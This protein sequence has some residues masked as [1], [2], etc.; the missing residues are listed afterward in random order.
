MAAKALF[1][2]D[3]AGLMLADVNGRL[4]WASASDERA[5]A[6]EDIEG[7]ADGPGP[8]PGRLHPGGPGGDADAR[9]EPSG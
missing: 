6:A 4:R 2:A 5:E 3:G 9:V 1:K 8:V 7:G